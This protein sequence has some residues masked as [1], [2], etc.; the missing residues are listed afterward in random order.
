VSLRQPE[1]IWD[2]R[3][4]IQAMA[5]KR[6]EKLLEPYHIGSVKTRNRMIKSGAAARYWGSGENQVSDRIKHYYEAFA[7]GG[8]GLIIVE[9]PLIEP[10]EA[11]MPGNYR[12]DDDK[13]IKGISE[14]TRLIHK[15]GCPAFVQFNHTANW[16]KKMPWDTTSTV[17]DPPRAASPVCIKSEMDNNNEMPREM[18]IAEIQEIVDKF[19]ST[20][21]RAR[22]AGFDGIEINAASTHLFNSF[23]S[24]FWNKRQDAYGCGSLENRA[25]FLVETLKEIKKRLGRD[26][27]ISIIING[28]EI[29]N[30]IGVENSECLTAEASRGIAQILQESG[31]DAIQVRS[32]W[33]GR[34]D[35]SFLTDHLY[36][37]E[38]PV[39][40]KSFPKEYY[41]GRRG[42]GAN[43]LL[44][45]AMKKVLTIP[46][47]TVG[48]LDPELGEK[49]LREGMTDFVCFNRRLIADPEL[50]N[51]VA[52]G[53]LDDIAPCTSCTTCKVMGGHRRCRINATIGT[54][55]TYVI[56]PAKKGKKVVVVGGGPAGM[57]AARVAALRGHEVILYEKTRKLGGL[58]PVAALVK[59]LEIECLPAIVRYL[60]GQITRLGVEI[61]LGKEADSSVIEAIKPDVV[62]LATGGVMASPEI[63]GINNRKVVSSADLHRRLKFL[64]KFI[65]PRTLRWLTK[66]WMPIGKRVVIIGGDIHGCELAEFLVKRGRKV[67]IVDTAEVLGEEITNHLRLQLFWWFRQKNVTM[68][69]GIKEYVAITDKGLTVLTPEGYKMTIE[70]DSI[71][72]AMPMK[73]DTALLR[74]LEGKGHEVYAIGDCNEPKLIVD[75]IGDGCRI[76]RTI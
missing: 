76:A 6:L 23:L 40:P 48:R 30:P 60:K 68:L 9:G 31:A 70:A 45:A 7:R 15:H 5:Y 14:L 38:P 67:T 36:Y 63:T 41:R 75:A 16:Q 53:R 33:L 25:R 42:A 17:S 66:F 39:P 13:Y 59:G 26:Y 64:L 8:I 49:M 62:I 52:S 37:P 47:M 11:R 73:P 22:K 71:V 65:G 27:P 34:H 3:R 74:S 10:V 50:P 21:V 72:P 46:V 20:A 44:A 57:E 58:L 54:D 18:T 32:Q 56:A 69:S 51:K 35:A 29:G 4:E 2:K 24:P 1:G 61:R 55:Q 12:L 43:M 28:I 19:G